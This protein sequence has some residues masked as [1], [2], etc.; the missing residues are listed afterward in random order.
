LAVGPP[1]SDITP[2]KPGTF[3]LISS[4]SAI[5]ESSLRL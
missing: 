2:V 5:I 3:N 1:R 4:I